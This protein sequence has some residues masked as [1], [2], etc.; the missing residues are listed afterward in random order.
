M[1]NIETGKRR[2]FQFSLWTLM[3]VVTLIAV[4]LSSVLMVGPGVAFPI[5]VCLLCLLQLRIKW[6]FEQGVVIAGR[7]T[8]IVFGSLHPE[9]SPSTCH[10]HRRA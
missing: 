3:L 8:A 2:R 7:N 5:N 1:S 9:T 10:P 6:A 4:L